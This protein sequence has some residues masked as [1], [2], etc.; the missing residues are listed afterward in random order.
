MINKVAHSKG[1]LVS[2]FLIF[3]LL[4]VVSNY[5]LH[6]PFT[7]QAAIENPY[8]SLIFLYVFLQ[9]VVFYILKK[10]WF[11]LRGWMIYVWVLV[12]MSLI[13]HSYLSKGGIYVNSPISHQFFFLS[14]HILLHLATAYVMVVSYLVGK[15]VSSKMLDEVIKNGE[16]FPVFVGIGI[17][18]TTLIL[19]LIGVGGWISFWLL[20]LSST[21]FI[22]INFKATIGLLNQFLFKKI[23]LHTLG[24][25]SFSLTSVLLLFIAVNLIGSYKYFPIGFDGASLYQNITHLIYQN[26]ALTSG[27]NAYNWSLFESYAAFLWGDMKYAIFLSHFMGLLVLVIL[28]HISALFLKP[29][30][31]WLVLTL[32]Y[33]APALTFHNF[34]DEKV[35]LAFLFFSLLAV[36]LCIKAIRYLGGENLMKKNIR[37]I[38]LIIGLIIGYAMGIKYLAVMLF[39]GVSIAFI[40]RYLGFKAVWPFLLLSIGG[41]FIVGADAFGISFIGSLERYILASV[42][43]ILGTGIICFYWYKGSFKN[44]LYP[45]GIIFFLTVGSGIGFSPWIIKNAV[46]SKRISIKSLLSG[47]SDKERLDFNFRWLKDNNIPFNFTEYEKTKLAEL[48]GINPDD[49][50]LSP[51]QYLATLDRD[52]IRQLNQSKRKG[53]G[54]KIKSQRQEE[55]QRY[56]GYE[57][58]FLRLLSLPVDISFNSNVI[59]LRSIDFSYLFL[60]LLPLLL[61]QFNFSIKNY[62]IALGFLLLFFLIWLSMLNSRGE[63][64]ASENYLRL[65]NYPAGLNIFKSW[66][67]FQFGLQSSIAMIF[68][69]IYHLL[70]LL[71]YTVSVFFLFLFTLLSSFLFKN[72]WSH[73]PKNLKQV[74]TISIAYFILWWIFGSGITYYA[75]PSIALGYLI[76][77]YFIQHK[78]IFIVNNQ[79]I[80]HFYSGG[81][82]LLILLNTLVHFT[83]HDN[84][85]SQRSNLF[86]APFALQSSTS[87]G[88]KDLIQNIN[89]SLQ[90]AIDMINNDPEAKVYRAGTLIEYHILNNNA[91]VYED[92]Q[93]GLFNVAFRRLT[94]PEDLF[95]FLKEKNFKY[96]ILDLGLTGID[97]TPEQSLTKKAQNLAELLSTTQKVELV[98]TDRVVMKTDRSSGK[99]IRVNDLEGEI[100]YPGSIAIFKII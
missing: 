19:F 78:D 3:W 70:S 21:A 84:S 83:N 8:Y 85:S 10:K 89:P 53:K 17:M 91:R 14:N 41:L 47:K 55:I 77:G 54:K 51:L 7:I 79:L 62:F 46:E 15:S 82:G 92:N 58:P 74:C 99:K 96:L 40:Y 38:I 94:N 36:F 76:V 56:I 63:P 20:F 98:L 93:L 28:Y 61:I 11:F 68:K 30:F 87:Y 95:L 100:V 64:L 45:I 73:L 86:Y 34:I 97:N 25:L 60:L 2:V 44:P 43:I 6:H 52:A 69:P 1:L 4:L 23:D 13:F 35:D 27:G 32:F 71:P 18:F 59:N 12:W 65:F 75:L 33:T 81:I 80:T 29:S 16:R 49:S 72:F 22:I 5:L 67:S 66:A 48:T 88:S 9:S 31:R 37:K 57:S 50:Q 24:L 26:G 39:I 42:F 90:K